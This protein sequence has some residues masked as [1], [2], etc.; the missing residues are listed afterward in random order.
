M[1][2]GIVLNQSIDC[3]HLCQKISTLINSYQKD[4]HDIENCLLSIEIKQITEYSEDSLLP[5]IEF[6]T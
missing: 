4:N 2:I 5:K 1:V 6:K 3:N